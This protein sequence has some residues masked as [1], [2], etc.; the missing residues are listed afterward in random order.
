MI[1]L[2]NVTK[3]NLPI[4][5]TNF[6]YWIG[7]YIFLPVLPVFY[8]Q[9]GF[10]EKVIGY[11]IGVFSFGA[12][13]TRLIVGYIADK[14]SFNKTALIGILLSNIAIFG[15]FVCHDTVLIIILRI[16]HGIGSAMYSAVALAIITLY[17]EEE[18]TMK[19]AIAL[20]TLFSMVGIG[21][22][23]SSAL[24]IFTHSNFNTII[25]IAF[26]T[27][28]ISLFCF[29]KVPVINKN[30]NKNI[31]SYKL[32]NLITDNN[33]FLPSF[34]QF[35]V[36]TCYSLIITF[37]PLIAIK[38]H[39]IKYLWLFYLFYSITVV[40]SRVGLKYI[41]EYI[42]IQKSSKLILI[43]TIMCFLLME[44]ITLSYLILIL[45]GI[46]LGI[47]VGTGTPTFASLVT[48]N[49]P[50]EARG[51]VMGFFSSSIDIGMVMGSILVGMF[52]TYYPYNNI[53]WVILLISTF[54][55]VLYT[56][57]VN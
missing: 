49:T 52:V 27:T 31:H 19:D 6:S 25:I 23:T 11:F 48:L 18:K 50:K 20:Y 44:I 28:M 21:F 1:K 38:Y 53:I 12:I 43:L 4:A 10:S 2:N 13:L 15:F 5:C 40:L 24:F 42:S 35:L 37:L 41:N 55:Y 9:Q 51:V 30:H 36:Y 34:A 22:I 16:F 57:S 47:T 3:K 54:Y 56:K 32:I 8:S 17:N 29:L 46:I 33:L 26:F 7:V 14:T 45:L 39:F